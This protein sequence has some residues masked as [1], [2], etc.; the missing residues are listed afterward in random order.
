VWLLIPVAATAACKLCT[1]YDCGNSDAGDC[2]EL[3]Y[4]EVILGIDGG[5]ALGCVS[6]DVCLLVREDDG[7]VP[8][9]NVSLRHHAGHFGR[10]RDRGASEIE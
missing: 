7:Q 2:S 8:A 5:H 3:A 9:D 1:L 4:H 10:R 6:A